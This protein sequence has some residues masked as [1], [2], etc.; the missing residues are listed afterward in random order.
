MPRAGSPHILHLQGQEE[1]MRR[2]AARSGTILTMCDVVHLV[3]K[4]ESG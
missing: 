2:S 3:L 1:G 4:V